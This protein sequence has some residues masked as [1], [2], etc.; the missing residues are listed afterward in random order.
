MVE[1][2]TCCLLSDS[3]HNYFNCLVSQLCCNAHTHLCI[4]ALLADDEDDDGE[5]YASNETG[6]EV[7]ASDLEEDQGEKK[8]K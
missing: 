1:G 7:T 6:S 4:I 5:D 8:T 3:C 2:R